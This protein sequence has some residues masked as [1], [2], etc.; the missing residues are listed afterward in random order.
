MYQC[1]LKDSELRVCR[2]RLSEV[3]RDLQVAEQEK[4]NMHKK[5]ELL[6]KALESPGSKITLRRILERSVRHTCSV[7]FSILYGSS[8]NN[9]N[10]QYEVSQCDDPVPNSNFLFCMQ[11]YARKYS[12]FESAPF[13][14]RGQ[15]SPGEYKCQ[16]SYVTSSLIPMC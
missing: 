8:Y 6:E 15:S 4:E 2:E 16:V 13:R 14:P 9:D 5:V 12:K 1:R 11:S 3:E 7:L 10:I